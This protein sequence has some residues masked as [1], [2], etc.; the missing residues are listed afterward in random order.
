MPILQERM[1]RTLWEGREQGSVTIVLAVFLGAGLILLAGLIHVG[2]AKIQAIEHAN[3]AAAEA[4]R[5]ASQQIDAP[6]AM[7]GDGVHLDPFAAV[8]AGQLALAVEGV[9]GTVSIQGDE[10]VV[11]TE[12]V[13]TTSLLSM[14]GIHQVTGEGYAIVR[15]LTSDPQG[16]VNE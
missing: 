4:A 5:V 3:E 1:R 11:H 2:G 6:A 10:V 7:V 15:I 12:A 9:T 14:I 8:H 16:L 13:T